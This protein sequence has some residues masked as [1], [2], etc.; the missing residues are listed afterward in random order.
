MVFLNTVESLTLLPSR[1]LIVLFLVVV[2]NT[3]IGGKKVK[4]EG[5][6]S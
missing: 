5:K 3:K 6:K 1:A 2:S 4:L